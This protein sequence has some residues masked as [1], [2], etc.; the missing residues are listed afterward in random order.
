VIFVSYC[1]GNGDI[2]AVHLNENF[3]LQR[4]TQNPNDDV[5][6]AWSAD[7]QQIAFVSSRD[8]NRELYLMNATTTD[9]MRLTNHPAVD[10]VPT[11]SK[12]NGW[13]AFMSLRD[14]QPAIYLLDTTTQAIQ[15]LVITDYENSLPIWRP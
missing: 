9:V 8:K 13:L 3:R 14:A 10:A 15:R 2:Y 1:T 11:W 6:P 4:L 7:N 5:T 12:E